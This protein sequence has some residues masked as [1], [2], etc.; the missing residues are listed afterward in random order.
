MAEQPNFSNFT[1]EQLMLLKRDKL[2][3]I[4]KSLKVSYQANTLKQELADNIYKHF[5]KET[6]PI[7]RNRD[8]KIRDS[9]PE[10]TNTSYTLTEI[11]L[12]NFIKIY[13]K[14]F[15]KQFTN[16]DNISYNDS[17]DIFIDNL[18]K[19]EYPLLKFILKSC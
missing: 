5:H 19:R 8:Y 11:Y 7:N 6:K 13:T 17:V 15:N 3:E 18:I 16:N 2:R 4:S 12:N 1:I 9:I 14:T 10:E